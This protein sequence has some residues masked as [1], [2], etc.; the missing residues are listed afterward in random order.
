[1]ISKLNMELSSPSWQ[2]AYR[3][4]DDALDLPPSERKAWLKRLAVD[5]A[6]LSPLLEQL[7]ADHESIE[8]DG[9]LSD[10]PKFTS[11]GIGRRKQA[12]MTISGA[13]TKG[14]LV[15][16]YRLIRELGQGGMGAVWLA[17]RIDG[18]IKR[19]V[20]L[21][22]PFTG[23]K[24]DVL[25]QRFARERDI[26]ASLTHVNIARL[27]DAGSTDSGQPYIALEY[28]E[29]TP[30]GEY[31]D[32]QK[33]SISAR[34]T[35]FR[36]V[37][38]A[39]QYAHAN[40]VIHR[41]LKPSNILVTH[42]GQVRL[43]DFGIA[44]LATTA[45]V[46]TTELTEL[47]GRALTTDYASPEQV[48]GKPISI[49]SDIYSLGIVLYEL[50][51]GSRP[52]RLKRGTRAE[53]EEAVLNVDALPMTERLE[54]SIESLAS[55]RSTNHVRL[56]SVLKGDINTLVL[57][58]INKAANERYP[59]VAALQDDLD[60]Y[61]AGEPI[62]A[63][64][65]TFWYALRK[66]FARNRMMVG[67]VAAVF[68]ALFAG[69]VMTLWQAREAARQTNVAQIE[70]A[71][72]TAVQKFMVELFS[73]KSTTASTESVDMAKR[74]ATTVRELLDV[75]VA[76]IDGELND[77]PESKLALISTIK[78]IYGQ[79]GLTEDVSKL[80]IK[81]RALAIQHFG[82]DSDQAIDA[83]LEYLE[84]LYTI[85]AQLP[86][87]QQPA[88]M[89]HYVQVE[90]ALLKRQ[91]L[92]SE[93][94]ARLLRMGCGLS[95]LEL[96]SVDGTRC[97]RALSMLRQYFPTSD[98]YT[99]LL[100][101]L[102]VRAIYQL[103]HGDG[104]KYSL[105]AVDV[106]ARL[107]NADKHDTWALGYLVANRVALRKFPEAKEAVQKLHETFVKDAPPLSLKR[108][109]AE[110]QMTAYQRSMFE[111][112]Q[113]REALERAIQSGLATKDG[114]YSI[115]VWRSQRTLAEVLTEMGDF[116]GAMKQFAAA[117]TVTAPGVRPRPALADP[118]TYLSFASALMK[119]GD[120]VRA[121][122]ALLRADAIVQ[123]PMKRSQF[124][125]HR[126]GT[127][128]AD[129]ELRSGEP[130]MALSLLAPLV[131]PAQPT[132][133]GPHVYVASLAALKARALFALGRIE[134]AAVVIDSPL[135]EIEQSRVRNFIPMSEADLLI[136]A[137]DVA[138]ARG[139][140]ADAVNARKRAISLYERRENPASPFLMERN[141]EQA[142]SYVRAGQPIEARTL[143][144]KQRRLLPALFAS[145]GRFYKTSQE[146]GSMLARAP[147]T[148]MSRTVGVAVVK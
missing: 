4:L 145:G 138:Q 22:L 106:Q 48:S 105:E 115:F 3:L 71:R 110:F 60:R 9:F 96:F 147:T 43:L 141:L 143:L 107:P 86:K 36:Q 109:D 52:Y 119:S 34:L 146:I 83:G 144:E 18:F 46:A 101:S 74:Q 11:I 122:E 42:D 94:Y 37:L 142:M 72:A 64:G 53:L 130:A 111:F 139:R 41:D 67:A 38:A 92:T 63:K 33:L 89:N 104:E 103:N 99:K 70:A 116:D 90:T 131:V 79:L 88:A 26:L 91:E 24:H 27:Y 84:A 75:G 16:P 112:A 13:L 35:L 123:T 69:L 97:D 118:F 56:K 31:C 29:G 2:E 10:M 58:A 98:T 121:R 20:A 50:L 6:H 81:K 137:A 77:Q 30:L 8:T 49:A 47:G 17:E 44:K 21:K 95:E 85:A 39:V 61:L 82:E 62:L 125:Q 132:S 19:P 65:E 54:K 55:L 7:L 148:A 14:L 124:W 80:A 40:L 57:K 135:R 127:L 78:G 5:R 120:H 66:L 114:E 76:K 136:V 117:M 134:E 68:L 100:N 45:E 25:V 140:H 113:V 93:R 133:Q 73:A 51:C 1:V 15:G 28:V 129:I 87:A 32:A 12:S 59:T 102:A 23:A 126:Y 108:V 128:L